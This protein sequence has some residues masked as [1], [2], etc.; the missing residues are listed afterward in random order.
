MPALRNS[1][2]TINWYSR[3]ATLAPKHS[4]AYF[5]LVMIESTTS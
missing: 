3:I 1:G 5:S 4:T 2:D